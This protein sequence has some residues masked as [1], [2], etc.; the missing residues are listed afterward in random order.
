MH[1]GS[2]G[3]RMSADFNRVMLLGALS[4][5]PEV[6]VTR[7]GQ[8]VLQFKLVTVEHSL[9]HEN[10][11]R[12]GASSNDI[13]V[14]GK[15]ADALSKALHLG[16]RVFVEGSLRTTTYEGRDGGKRSKTEVIASEVLLAGGGT[17]G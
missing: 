5:E 12:A 10:V 9:D 6:Y 8:T 11:P 17:T 2:Y 13:V 14:I 16:N 7:A 3:A 1:I 4:T 15:R